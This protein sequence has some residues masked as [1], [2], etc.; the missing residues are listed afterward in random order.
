MSKIT[1]AMVKELRERTGVG[2][3]KCKKALDENN[4]DVEQ[5]I[6]FLRKA[7]A[8][9]AVKKESRETNEGVIGFAENSDKLVLVEVNAETDFVTQNEKFKNFV[10]EAC[11]VAL[12]NGAENVDAL[13]QAKAKDGRTFEE[14]RVELV[15]T[16]GENMQFKRVQ[17]LPKAQDASYGVYSHMGGKIL[18]VVELSGAKGR[19]D[20]ARDVAMHVAAEAP[21]YLS[22]ED[23]P[24]EMLE[25][26]KDIAREQVK[27]KPDNIIEKILDGKM[28]A[29]YDQVC[30]PRQ[31][32]V[33]DSS[34]TVEAFVAKEANGAK[35]SKFIRWQMGE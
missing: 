17:C 28:R 6:D 27:G 32:F 25:R 21:E 20:L 26:E 15:Q 31:K 5:A 30:L 18:T 7:G 9:S 8:A 33:K 4:G 12:E 2:M 16:M 14:V 35:I 10:K 3:A 13:S 34:M 11:D 1:P 23:I 24:A 29:F 22:P 19:E